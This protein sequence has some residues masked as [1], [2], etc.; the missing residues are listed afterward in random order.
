[1]TTEGASLIR[2]EYSVISPERKP[3]DNF[4][5]DPAFANELCLHILKNA[6]RKMNP[7]K[8]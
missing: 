3:R 7:P 5:V 1:M 2:K 8:Q 4:Y 6:V